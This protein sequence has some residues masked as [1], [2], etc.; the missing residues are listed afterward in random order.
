MVKPYRTILL[1]LIVFAFSMGLM[2]FFPEDG[3]EI[4][5]GYSL[6]FPDWQSF[7]E[8]DRKERRVALQELMDIYTLKIDSTA[9]RDSLKRKR[10]AYQQEMKKLQFPVASTTV[11]SGLAQGLQRVQKEGKQIRFIHYG[12]SQ[13]EGD[14]ITSLIR[15]KLQSVYGGS[16]AGWISLTEIVPPTNLIFTSSDNWER[17]TV[18]G[19]PNSQLHN[20]Y[21]MMGVFSRFTPEKVQVTDV[22]SLDTPKVSIEPKEKKPVEKQSKQPM[23]ET[24]K[25]WIQFSPSKRGYANTRSFNKVRLAYGNM[26]EP[27]KYTVWV[28]GAMSEEGK[29]QTAPFYNEL[30][31]KFTSTPSEVRIEFESVDSPDFYG[32]SMESEGGVLVDNIAMRGSSGTIFNKMDY[33]LLSAQLSKDDVALIILQYGGNSVPYIKSV[34]QAEDYGRWFQ[35]QIRTLRRLAPQASF[36]VIGPSD[37]ATKEKDKFVTYPFL[38]D[39]RNALQKAAFEQGAAYWDMFEAMGG[40]GSMPQWVNADPPLASGD[41]IHFSPSGAKLVAEWFYEALLEGLQTKSN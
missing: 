29:L 23:A 4:V 37:M 25:A 24:T 39:V 7:W 34:E 20:K 10:I 31:L 2:R 6:K 36:I 38:A 30:V 33:G 11:L 19:K 32:I 14:R 28:D 12:D 16:G 41:H 18:Y 3:I 9:I 26:E 15:N 1:L 21:G 5:D 35:S 27:V 13:I 8:E 22:D 17:F 40:E